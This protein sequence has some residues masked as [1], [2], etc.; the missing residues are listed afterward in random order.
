LLTGY[1]GVLR[2]AGFSVQDVADDD[3]AFLVCRPALFDRPDTP[4]RSA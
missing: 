1:A 2:L 4:A 3:E